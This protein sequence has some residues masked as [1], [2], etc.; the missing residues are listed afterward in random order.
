[1]TGSI[2][3]APKPTKTVVLKDDSTT[4][5]LQHSTQETQ[6][7]DIYKLL[8]DAPDNYIPQQPTHPKTDSTP[9]FHHLSKIYVSIKTSGNDQKQPLLNEDLIGH[10]QFEKDRNLSYLPISTSLTLKH[11]RHM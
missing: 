11:K 9:E 6:H 5:N 1:M 8:Y 4:Q 7:D 2:S 10:L 3:R